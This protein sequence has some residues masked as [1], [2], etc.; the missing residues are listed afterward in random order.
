MVWHLPEKG[1]QTAAERQISSFQL[2]L[3]FPSA[4]VVKA[5][6]L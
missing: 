5:N 1:L 2:A 6:F 3:L 4:V